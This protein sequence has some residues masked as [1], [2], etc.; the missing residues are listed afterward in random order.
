ME[1]P[2]DVRK[3]IPDRHNLSICK[4]KPKNKLNCLCTIS[5][6]QFTDRLWR[7]HIVRASVSSEQQVLFINTL[8]E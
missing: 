7:A 2:T 3:E 5:Q 4:K 1:K 6:T 8:Y